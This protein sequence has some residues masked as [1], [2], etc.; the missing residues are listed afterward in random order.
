MYKPILVVVAA[1]LFC[2]SAT[3]AAIDSA[4]LLKDDTLR[5]K[6]FLD[7]PRLSTLRRGSSVQL[8][9]RHGAWTRV[10]SSTTSGWVR[11]LS[12]RSGSAVVRSGTL[13]RINS[14][15]LGT[16]R[17]V[18]T[19]GIRGLNEDG[20]GALQKAEFNGA[21]LQAAE[22]QRVSSADATAFARRG[23]LKK[24]SIQW[25]EGQ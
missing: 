20:E 4:I 3:A 10:K 18:S 24:R 16:G 2:L 8:V 6:P 19:T 13:S 23:K 9:K 25:L 7:A 11:S 12:L 14:G 5:S 21:A 22:N 15:R 17:I 1:L